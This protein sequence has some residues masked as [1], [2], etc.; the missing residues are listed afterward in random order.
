MDT[1]W[2]DETAG[3]TTRELM[4][5][6]GGNNRLAVDAQAMK[7]NANFRKSG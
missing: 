7:Q 2:C 6:N 5:A 3:V 1:R 4:P